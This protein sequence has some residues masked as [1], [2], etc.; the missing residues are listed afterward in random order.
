MGMR[1]KGRSGGRRNPGPWAGGRVGV[2]KFV[3]R[4]FGL[5][6]LAPRPLDGGGERR[7]GRVAEGARLESV[8]ALI[9]YRG[10]ESLSLRQL[11]LPLG[12]SVFFPVFRFSFRA[13]SHT[14]WN[15]RRAF[16]G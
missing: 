8:Y 3:A 2:T 5:R 6:Y 15:L 13:L 14:Q 9:A 12:C 4:Q 16:I 1:C 10:F 7:D 11:P